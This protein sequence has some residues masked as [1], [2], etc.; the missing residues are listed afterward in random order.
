MAAPERAQWRSHFGF[1]MA[2]SG[3][4]VGLGNLWKFPY[5]AGKNGGGVFVLVYIIILMLVG[6][7]IMLGEMVVGRAT[8]RNSYGAYRQ[9]NRKWSWVGGMG[10][11]AGFFILGFY[12]VIGGWVMRYILVYLTPATHQTPSEFFTSFITHPW[13]PL[14]F[15]AL[16]VLSNLFIVYRGIASGIEAYS[17]VLMPGL[18]ILLLIIVIRSVTL[19]N[20]MEGIRFYLMPDWSQFKAS[21]IVAALGQVFFSLS[22]GMGCMITYGSY[23]NKEENLAQNALIVPSIDTLVALLS[24]FAILPA[25]FAFNYEPSAGPSLMFITLPEVFNKMP[26]SHLFGF[27]FF[28]LVFFAAL[29][30]SISLFEVT[31]AYVVDEFNWKRGRAVAVLGLIV[32]LL[33]IPCSL[34]F[35]PMKDATLFGLTFF[36]LLDFLASN[37]MLPLGGLLLAIFIGYVW[38]VDKAVGEIVQNGKHSFPLKRIWIILIKYLAPAALIIVFLDATGLF[39]WFLSAIG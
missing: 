30:S 39:K 11:L 14:L 9:L 22:L 23:L 13:Y 12:S 37:I 8:Q 21:T 28:L 32:F 26:L 15:L 20:A 1:L 7:T 5:L 10:V 18:F 16:F 31:I 2:A 38:G 25:V 29:T 33:A 4:A 35:G 36:D 19:D 6:F 3:S 17:Q 34:S 27:I 24:G